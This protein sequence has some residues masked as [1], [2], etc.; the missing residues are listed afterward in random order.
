MSE[1]YIKEPA[2]KGKAILRT[3][4]GD[5][6]VELW[7]T[8]CPKA[9]R[10]FCQLI[11]EGYYNGT[12]FHR[13]IKDFIIQGGDKTGTGNGC[14]SIYDSPYPDEIH[15]R[16]KFRYRGMMGVASAGKGTK[17]N[18]SQFFIVLNRAPSLDGKHTLFAKV[19]GQTVYN[20]VQMC[21]VEVDKKDRPIQ[22]PRILRAELVW[23]PFGD[24]EPRFTPPAALPQ[25]GKASEQQHRRAPVHNKRI[26]SFNADEEDEEDGGGGGPPAKGKSAHDLLNDPKLSRDA[27]YPERKAAVSGAR[28]RAAA[29]SVGGDAA[30]EKR[31]ASAGSK[32]ARG[33][34]KPAA[35]AP[36]RPEEEADYGDSGS[37]D[38]EESDDDVAVGK[39]NK[40][41]ET[42]QQLKRDIVGLN[43]GGTA[44]KE[45]KKKPKS[46]WE[47]LT[48]G[49]TTRAK[50]KVEDRAGR[51]KEAADVMSKLKAFSE[52]LK[53]VT[54]STGEDEEQKDEEE[55][56]DK[57]EEG[58][59]SAIWHE[60]EEEGD[61][62]WLTGGGL[63]FHVS[64]D[65][66]FKLA[67]DKARERLEIFDPLAAK[68]NDE[69]LAEA[70]KRRSAQMTPQLRRK[71]PEKLQKW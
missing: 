61:K 45:V 39:S 37:D 53:D 40:R 47:E 59:F 31:T 29:E 5:L 7:A 50:R 4:H 16:L 68:G 56:K 63:K 66:A 43:N 58:T 54:A 57:K 67:S 3:T 23:D 38:D 48:A 2:T 26:L 65:K 11:L 60:G 1:V 62:D 17:T 10:N 6:E 19:V 21:E 69:V 9:C 28:K 52:R 8:E 24:L 22:P 33:G 36:E 55:E 41:Q 46:A 27:A 14:E 20:L 35:T 64:G 32:G 30:F 12:E 13:I 34:A 44:S 25:A 71:E 15:P 18:G 42:I 70:R 49:Y 51:K